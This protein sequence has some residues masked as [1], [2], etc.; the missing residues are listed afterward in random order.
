MALETVKDL[1]KYLDTTYA[2]ED[3]VVYAIYSSG[4]VDVDSLTKGATQDEVWVEVGPR[5]NG[6]LDYVQQEI[7]EALNEYTQAYLEELK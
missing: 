6:A 4:D 5:L 1:I 3:K 7:I 2:Q